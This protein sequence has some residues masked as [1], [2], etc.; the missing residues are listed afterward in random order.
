MT[1]QT[2]AFSS[3]SLLCIVTFWVLRDTAKKLRTREVSWTCGLN[4]LHIHIKGVSGRETNSIW[5]SVSRAYRSLFA[6]TS[7]GDCRRFQKRETIN[8]LMPHFPFP[9]VVRSILGKES[10]MATLLPSLPQPRYSKC[11]PWTSHMATTWELIRNARFMNQNLILTRSIGD[12][13][14]S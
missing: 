4:G 2:Q 10:T 12:P 5:T 9:L 14:L 8:W 13:C 11:G 1:K 6:V 3:H 7:L